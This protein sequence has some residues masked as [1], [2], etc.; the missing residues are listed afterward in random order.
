MDLYPQQKSFL[1][2]FLRVL[3]YLLLIFI[4]IWSAMV[5]YSQYSLRVAVPFELPTHIPP[6]PA[7]LTESQKSK[8]IESLN[9]SS[10]EF[11]IENAAKMLNSI[12]KSKNTL[13]DEE[14]N[15]ILEGLE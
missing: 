8:I 10:T 12:S 11:K 1:S 15:K 7:P 6:A 9:A 3:T 4:I 5:I 13:T 14:K 2:I